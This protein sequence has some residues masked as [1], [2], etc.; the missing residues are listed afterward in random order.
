MFNN[1]T[2][3]IKDLFGWLSTTEYCW[4]K[5]VLPMP[6]DTPLQSDIDILVRANDIPATLLF[7]AK[8][9]SVN[10]CQTTQKN[11]ATYLQI[12]FNDGSD[13]KLDLLTALVRKQYEYLPEAYVFSNRI[14]KNGVATYTPQLLLE[15]ALLFNFL[16]NAGLPSKYVQHFE[17][18][19]E[20]EQASLLAF[21]NGK[22]GT[23][24]RS[25][26]QMAHFSISCQQKLE[27]QLLRQAQNAPLRRLRRGVGFAMG[28]IFSTKTSL[29]SIITFSGV[30][31]AG[32]TTLLNDLRTV[33]TEKLGKEVVVLRHRPSLLPILSAYKHG[34][35]EAEARSIARLPRQGN[36]DSTLSSL[37]RFSY[38]FADFL[39]GQG[40]IWLRHT[41]P[42]RTV[43]Y[44]RYY[45]DFIVDAKRTNISL[46]EALPKWL[47]R[48]VAK[49]GL[50]VFLHASPDVIRQRKQEMPTG[51]IVEMTARYR[52]LFE[53]LGSQ[54]SGHYLS[55]ENHDRRATL[56][57][58]LT[59]YFS[60][61][62][63]I[64]VHQPTST[65]TRP[66]S[67]VHRNPSTVLHP[68]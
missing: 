23:A 4:L 22:Y 43:I 32:K 10:C 51:D 13:L 55:I 24:F 41:L 35:Q 62:S 6:E 29:P 63:Q 48:F 66:P 34:R 49:P 52:A 2:Q 26:R 36:N 68:C 57:A 50:N 21:L 45:F 64:T 20:A 56:D 1:R 61:N 17:A 9:P 42:G 53:E 15:H 16:N 5:A 60:K 28:R 33:L 59:H 46:G 11:E 38:Y 31:G 47:Y 44:D 54:Y 19:T 58:I 40:Y 67:T 37:L 18:K 12:S 30:D 25:F 39:I 27:T 8:H 7:V 3:F 65:E 14:W